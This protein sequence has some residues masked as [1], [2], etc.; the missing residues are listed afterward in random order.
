MPP[1]SKRSIKTNV[2][3]ADSSHLLKRSKIACLDEDGL[4][5][6]DSDFESVVSPIV[7]SEMN[8]IDESESFDVEELQTPKKVVKSYSSTH[9]DQPKPFEFKPF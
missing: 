7:N 8:S 4:D 3:S 1:K 6:V 9:H 2:D 5:I